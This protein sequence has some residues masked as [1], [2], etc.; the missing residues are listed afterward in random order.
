MVNKQ[1]IAQLHFITDYLYTNILSKYKADALI[2]GRKVL[3]ELL[4]SPGIFATLRVEPKK[5]RG[6]IAETMLKLVC[7]EWLKYYKIK[8]FYIDNLILTT[9]EGTTQLDG[10]L[11]T[12]KFIACI[13]SKSYYGEV[14]VNGN[15]I[16]HGEKEIT[17]PWNQNGTHINA[18]LANFKF[19]VGTPT[20]NIVYL[21][22]KGHIPKGNCTI[23]DGCQLMIN[24]NSFTL[25]SSLYKGKTYFSVEQL[26]KIQSEL[27]KYQPTIE[28]EE[29]H[30]NYLKSIF[31]S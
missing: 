9:S 19:L 16:E 20:Y 30:I 27:I 1:E 21:F 15:N 18:L 26:N 10:L 28:Q 5:G 6:A 11:I 25:L 29:Q 13:E 2:K 17:Y 12:D 22:S 14:I 7:N 24:I 31:N 23:V 3:V 8:G 4:D